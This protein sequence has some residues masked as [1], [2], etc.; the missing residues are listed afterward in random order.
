VTDPVPGAP[1]VVQRKCM[2]A[3]CVTWFELTDTTRFYCGQRTCPGVVRLAEVADLREQN[4]GL[5]QIGVA[6]DAEIE[7]L[8]MRVPLTVKMIEGKPWTTWLADYSQ[9]IGEC[10]A[11]ERERDEARAV[12]ER[13][14][15]DLAA[16]LDAEKIALRAV[17]AEN[18]RL[19]AEVQRETERGDALSSQLE[20]AR[21]RLRTLEEAHR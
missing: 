1:T 9:K 21:H 12:I 2:Y 3:G 5:L 6:R 14:R 20:L 4:K 16:A 18:E 11:A 7:R 17:G 10:Q 8:Q 13:L 19:R 15:A